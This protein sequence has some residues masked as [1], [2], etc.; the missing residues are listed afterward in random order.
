VLTSVEAKT[1]AGSG[2]VRQSSARARRQDASKALWAAVPAVVVLGAAA[3][4]VATPHAVALHAEAAAGEELTRLLRMM[5]G[6]KL[7]IV[8]GA[9]F[10]AGWRLRYPVAPVRAGGFLA[11]LAAMAA[12]P[13]LIWGMAHVVAGAALLHGGML[14]FLLLL[15]RDPG[16]PRM[17]PT[18]R[19]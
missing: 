5:A 19:R 6:L 2:A 3:G 8:L 17:L 12:G 1:R 14:C 4:F 7:A 13:G 18:R 15:W 16:S 10:L 11:S 9:A